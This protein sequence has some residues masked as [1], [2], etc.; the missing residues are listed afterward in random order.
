MIF[1]GAVA[2]SLPAL[3]L[4]GGRVATGGLVRRIPPLG[5]WRELNAGIGPA[6]MQEVFLVS[7]R[8]PTGGRRHVVGNTGDEVHLLDERLD[9]LGTDNDDEVFP[10][11]EILGSLPDDE[12]A[13]LVRV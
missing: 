4:G 3:A 7:R 13:R 1:D 8:W 12:V 9:V 10:V 11:D 2:L 5:R 6:R